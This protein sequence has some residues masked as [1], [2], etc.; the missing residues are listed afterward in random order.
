MV[1]GSRPQGADHV[2]DKGWLRKRQR[3]TSGPLRR[4]SRC[5]ANLLI[6]LKRAA[7]NVGHVG[8]EGWRNVP[9]SRH[10]I[11]ETQRFLDLADEIGVDYL[12]FAN[13]Q[14]YN[15][16]MLNRSELLPTREQLEQAEAAIQ[17]AR[18]RPNGRTTIYSVSTLNSPSCD[19]G[20]RAQH[21]ILSM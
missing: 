4:C 6:F 1:A 3:G 20:D 16:A 21:K 14:Y 9:V 19:R 7:R 11:H 18:A 12:E 13:L 8:R 15:W 10:N 17:A 2:L 5:S